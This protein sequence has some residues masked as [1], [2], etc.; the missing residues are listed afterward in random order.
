VTT[1]WTCAR[2]V[3]TAAP[4]SSV[5]TMREMLPPRA[6]DG[7]ACLGARQT[8]LQRMSVPKF[9]IGEAGQ[10]RG[11]TDHEGRQRSR[12]HRASIPVLRS[13]E[14][15]P[16]LTGARWTVGEVRTSIAGCSSVRYPAVP[17]CTVSRSAAAVIE[18]ASTLFPLPDW[19][20][21]YSEFGVTVTQTVTVGHQVTRR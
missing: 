8:T 7:S 5:G 15:T 18:S 10:D 4:A 12:E 16:R 21:V 13:V 14:R 2:V 11:P 6:V 1:Q 20:V 17:T 19:A 9:R 3:V